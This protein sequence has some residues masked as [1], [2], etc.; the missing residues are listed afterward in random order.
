MIPLP[1]SLSKTIHVQSPIIDPGKQPVEEIAGREEPDVHRGVAIS[2]DRQVRR[3]E[4]VNSFVG[5]KSIIVIFFTNAL[6]SI[7]QRIPKNWRKIPAFSWVFQRLPKSPPS[8]AAIAAKAKTRG[9]WRRNTFRDHFLR[10]ASRCRRVGHASRQASRTTSSPSAQSGPR[11]GA[12]EELNLGK[13]TPR[14]VSTLSSHTGLRVVAPQKS[15]NKE[16]HFGCR[17][18]LGNIGF[19]MVIF[20]TYRPGVLDRCFRRGVQFRIDTSITLVVV[21]MKGPLPCLVQFD[22]HG[23]TIQKLP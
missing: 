20:L 18:A 7:I 13:G 2:T 21:T 8:P 10:Q 14:E 16:M 11:Q 5:P 15:F 4:T 12:R 19:A 6:H 1:H 22:D 9:G 23:I 3:R 17:I